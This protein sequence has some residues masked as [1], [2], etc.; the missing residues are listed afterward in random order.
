MKL[1]LNYYF[2][3]LLF[4]LIY[5]YIPFPILAGTK[6]LLQEMQVAL[7]VP[8]DCQRLIKPGSLIK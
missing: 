8:P 7:L 4:F 1:K 2:K 6:H 3:S 5:M